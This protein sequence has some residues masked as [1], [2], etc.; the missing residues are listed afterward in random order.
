[1]T[2]NI[3]EKNWKCT[4]DCK[5]KHFERLDSNLNEWHWYYNAGCIFRQS[6]K[7]H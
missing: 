4:G 6:C 2:R 1:M 7:W 3:V 5:K